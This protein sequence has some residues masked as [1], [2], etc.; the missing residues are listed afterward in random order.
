MNCWK[1]I[2]ARLKGMKQVLWKE[3]VFKHDTKLIDCLHE[4]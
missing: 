2:N 4:D 3:K 1:N